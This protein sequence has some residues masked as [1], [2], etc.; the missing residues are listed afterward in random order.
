MRTTT[1]DVF[2]L[3]QVTAD[4]LR[5]A[6]E[7]RRHYRCHRATSIGPLELARLAEVLGLGR[8]DV[9]V[10]EFSLL[11]GESQESPW[12]VSF[13]GELMSRISGLSEGEARTVARCWAAAREFADGGSPDVLQAYLTGLGEFARASDGPY[14][15]YVRLRST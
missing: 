12:V 5:W 10:R 1:T 13:P 2:S 6:Q 7:P 15:L 4:E 9:L 11:A 14:A 3:A 8:S